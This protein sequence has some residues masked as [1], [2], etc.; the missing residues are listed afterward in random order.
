M[1]VCMYVCNI[2]T[3]SSSPRVSCC[4]YVYMYVCMYVCMC[5][6]MYTLARARTHT[7][8]RFSRSGDAYRLL[9]NNDLGQRRIPVQ[10]HQTR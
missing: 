10:T 9:A 4:I 7:G 8:V 1:Y 2:H 6:F 3:Y 5:A